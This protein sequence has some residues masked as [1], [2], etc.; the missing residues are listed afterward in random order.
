MAEQVEVLRDSRFAMEINRRGCVDRIAPAAATAGQVRPIGA[1]ADDNAGR[2]EAPAEFFDPAVRGDCVIEDLLTHQNHSFRHHA[3]MTRPWRAN[4]QWV[5]KEDH[6]EWN[7]TIDG[8]EGDEREL[9]VT[10]S[11]PHPIF[12][13]GMGSGH[14]KWDLWLPTG[15]HSQG[16][17]YGL[18]K[19][20]FSQCLDE[21]TDAPLPLVTLFH[22]GAANLGFSCLL[23]PDQMWYADFEVDQRYW[24]TRITFKH[25]GLQKGKSIKLRLWCF[26]HAG[27]WR[28]A[29]GWVRGRFPELLGPVE[30]QQK[31]DG[32]MA[33][34]IPINEK[35]IADWS[36]KMH[37]RWNELIHWRNFGDYCPDEPFNASHFQS[38]ANPHWT[39]DNLRYDDLNRYIDMCHKHNV[40]VM[41]YFNIS[42]CE[43]GI[44]HKRFPES[45]AKFYDNR[46][47]VCWVYYDGKNHNVVMNGDPQYPYFDFVV[48]QYEK[49]LK[50]C[51]GIDGLFFDQVCYGWIDT[52]HFD[53]ET[54]WNNKPAYNLGNMYVRAF[55]E[56]RSRLPRPRII[57]LGNG[58]VRW[59]LM[60]YI[61]GAMAEG[62][63]ETLGRFSLICPERPMVC[64][65]EGENAF[66]HA[67][68]H[69]SWM[70][71][72][73][74]Y[75]Y[76]TTEELPT[77]A[78]KLFEMYQPLLNWLEGRKMV[79]EPN[80][81]KV[82]AHFENAYKSSLLNLNENVRANIFRTPWGDWAVVVLALPK[83]A[84][85]PASTVPLTINVNIP[86]AGKLKHAA[87]FNVENAG[88]TIQTPVRN[89]DGS[90]RVKIPKHGA[91]SLVILSDNIERL[92][93]QWQWKSTENQ[94]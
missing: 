72:S 8:L 69:G 23:P 59:Q 9:R 68:F 1:I 13:G 85:L 70:H 57:G 41:P 83:G 84:V 2:I 50:R 30:G 62:D 94:S 26:S 92:R 42:E 56:F 5:A 86:E 14:S 47:M 11:L 91:A 15:Q 58:I 66:Q 39:A 10:L 93:S 65:A 44:A 55:K 90:V 61:D 28:P 36:N 75:R 87:V 82:E 18:R 64:L 53:G 49:L 32:N 73:P 17:E 38:P 52:A 21:K 16:A 35:R 33:Y 7:L 54:F 31:L 37:L 48:S 88:H 74:Y 25:L 60:Q 20:H 29:M 6:W 4:Q 76:P 71:V 81:L 12:P 43:S 67:L 78:I 40:K 46:E 3:P 45:I 89:E 63:P 24:L 80:P 79:Y 27:D 22:G 34:T 19:I 77:D 51:P